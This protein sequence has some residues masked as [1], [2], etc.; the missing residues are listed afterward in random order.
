MHLTEPQKNRR[1]KG[2]RENGSN[3]LAKLKAIQLIHLHPSIQSSPIQSPLY[4]NPNISRAV[5]TQHYPTPDRLC[6]FIKK[7]IPPLSLP[8]SP[9]L[10]HIS[11]GP[12][13]DLS[14]IQSARTHFLPIGH[15]MESVGEGERTIAGNI[16]HFSIHPTYIDEAA[17]SLTFNLKLYFHFTSFTFLLLVM[18]PKWLGLDCRNSCSFSLP[19]ILSIGP[20]FHPTFC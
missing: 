13:W 8:S 18:G 17:S 16:F 14:S 19:S 5:N 4:S 6:R 2:R 12:G 10:A 9:L 15:P 20:N 11:K 7:H 3:T 1:R